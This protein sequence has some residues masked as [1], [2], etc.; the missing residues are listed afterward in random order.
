MVT[1]F[2]L[3]RS[4][5]FSKDL[6][7]SIFY[8]TA[9]QVSVN[10]S[11]M[12]TKTPVLI[13]S[14]Y[15]SRCGIATY[16]E[17][18]AEWL[19]KEN[20]RI[21]ICAP[22]EPDSLV[23]ADIPGVTASSV[24]GRTSPALADHLLPVAKDFDIIHFQHEHGL[25]RSTDAFFQALKVFKQRGKKIVV[26]LHTVHTYGDW[27]NT[28]FLDL[29]RIHADI[30]IVHTPA[31]HAAVAA[32]RG[33][34][35]VIRIPHGTRCNVQFGDR[36][37][38]MA[39]LDVPKTWW[40]SVIGGTFGFIGQGKALHATL[41][42]FADG[43]SRRLIDTSAKYIV[44]GSAHDSAY[45]LFLRSVVDRSG[46]SG[47]IFLRDDLF[48]P[49]EK[50]RHV[51]AVFDYAVLNTE[52]WTLSAS[53]QTH[54]HAAY[55]VP[56]AVARRPIYD[57]AIQAGALPY[58]TEKN[59]HDVTLSHVNAIAALASSSTV[60]KQVK[61]SMLAFGK[62]TGWNKVAKQHAA[63]YAALTK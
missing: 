20:L 51:M 31:G 26:T 28:R 50:V 55:G 19:V 46:C 60:R 24:W 27:E 37:E 4:K 42:A 14:T 52:S 16:T 29:V 5:P 58:I 23:N 17:E 1:A 33:D 57:E 56:L 45:R 47:N 39:Y 6:F 11:D 41:Q 10:F 21:H 22:Q 12:P 43:L 48:V 35:V 63:V 25:F 18:L 9:R 8:L 44:C 32:A 61:D 36:T 13:V 38:G 53:G 40:K 7:S 3:V 54:V 49:R 30:V 59:T 34:A 2:W 62:R 15:G